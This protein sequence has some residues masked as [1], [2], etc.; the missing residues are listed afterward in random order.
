MMT[1]QFIQSLSEAQPNAHLIARPTS[2]HLPDT[3]LINEM[4]A[5]GNMAD[6]CF[7]CAPYKR[8]TLIPL[9]LWQDNLTDGL[10]NAL[11]PLFTTPVSS[12]VIIDVREI[13]ETVLLQVLRF[14]FNQVHRLDDLQLKTT[15]NATIRLDHITALC[16]PEQ[17]EALEKIF[18]RQQAIANGMVAAR[19]LA[20]MPSE[21][22]TPQFVVEEAQRLCAAYPDLRCEVLDEQAIVAQ[23]LGLLHAVGKGASRPPRLLAIH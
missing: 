18:R 9:A 8:I 1:Y 21:Q 5:T 16:L 15:D 10:L 20:D 19:R 11:R 23:G 4:R 17:Q 14:L 13:H 22:C 12:H 2:Q 6:T 7:G 3:A